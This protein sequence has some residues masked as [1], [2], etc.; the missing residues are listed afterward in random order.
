MEGYE[1]RMTADFSKE[2][3]DRRKALLA[4]RPRLHQLEVKY[5]LF[6]PARM[7]T[8]KNGVSKDFYD[9]E[10]LRLFLES[11]QTQYMD[12]IT[13]TWPQELSTERQCAL[14]RLSSPGKQA[15]MLQIFTTGGEI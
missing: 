7:W 15:I 10:D 3:S 5:G 8:T 14:P 13:P 6:K 1:I 11:L 4:L 2:T 9:P 12:T